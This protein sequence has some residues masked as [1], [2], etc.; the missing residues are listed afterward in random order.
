M[1]LSQTETLRFSHEHKAYTQLTGVTN[2]NKPIMCKKK[3]ITVYPI[4]DDSILD[5]L[6]PP[7]E[8]EDGWVYLD[9]QT[10]Q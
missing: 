10:I 3:T 1:R 8:D 7:S 4:Y 5:S 9:G 2:T 6:L